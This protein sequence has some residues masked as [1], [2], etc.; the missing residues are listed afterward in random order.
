M[1]KYEAHLDSLHQTDMI[2]QN[3]TVNQRG[4]YE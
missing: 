4:N 3:N 2:A 1:D